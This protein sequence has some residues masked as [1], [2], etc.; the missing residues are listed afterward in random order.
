MIGLR[1]GVLSTLMWHSQMC[2]SCQVDTV[3]V[4]ADLVVDQ[5]DEN[6]CPYWYA[7]KLVSR[8]FTDL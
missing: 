3:C 8:R 5:L 2:T 1:T 7:V 4:Q 6:L